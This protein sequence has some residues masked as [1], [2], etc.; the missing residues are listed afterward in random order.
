MANYYDHNQGSGGATD[1][2]GSDTA[3]LLQLPGVSLLYRI[4]KDWQ[5]EFKPRSY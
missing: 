4:L 5:S 1:Q 2:S 3:L